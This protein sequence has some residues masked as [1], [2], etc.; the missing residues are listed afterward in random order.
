[1]TTPIV[2][3]SVRVISPLIA[4]YSLY[5]LLKGHNEPGGGFIGGLLLG[6][7]VI[8]ADLGG[9]KQRSRLPLELPTLIGIGACLCLFSTVAAILLGQPALT[10]SW[11]FG[12]PLPILG[13]I[14]VGSVLI[15]DFGVYFLVAAVVIKIVNNIS[16]TQDA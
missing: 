9:V 14:K 5:V 11:W 13:E 3:A 7:A 15:F 8:Y 1:M 10:A 12:I 16:W 4:F 6:L 2:Q